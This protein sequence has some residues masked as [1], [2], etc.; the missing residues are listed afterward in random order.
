MAWGA[1]I[2]VLALLPVLVLVD[3]PPRRA[4]AGTPPADTPPAATPA[5]ATP[6]R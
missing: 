6:A 2:L 3:A 4:A 1:G 5:A